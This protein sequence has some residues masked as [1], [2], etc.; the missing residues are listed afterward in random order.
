MIP[1]GDFDVI[2]VGAG[3]CGSAAAAKLCTSG[4]RVLLLERSERTARRFGEYL[5]SSACSVVDRSRL[6]DPCW[7]NEHLESNEF[8]SAW[9]G[10][11][12]ERNSILDVRGSSIVLNRARFDMSFAHAARGAGAV[13][14]DRVRLVSV[15]RPSGSWEIAFDEDGRS[16]SA[17]ASFLVLCGGRNGPRINCLPVQRRRFDKLVCLGMRLTSYTGDVRPAVETYENGWAYSVGVPGGELMINLFTE[18]ERGSSFHPSKSAEFFL[19]E[20][21]QCGIA[22]SRVL[23][24]NAEGI[25]EIFSAD[26]SSFRARPAVGP[27]W[28][29]AGDCAQSMDPLSSSGIMHA[30]EHAECLAG[31]L[32]RC[33]FLAGAVLGQY[34]Q[35]LDAKY[36]AYLSERSSVYAAER[37]R[38]G[39]FWRRRVDNSF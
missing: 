9:G 5:S 30:L 38:S 6:L 20:I 21:S 36:E 12:S 24:G 15:R 37:R 18:S 19:R 32:E 33:R 13:L 31:E 3:V 26:A 35:H 34:G 4:F 17:S 27:G 23:S 28:C 2:V 1:S 25:A 11:P 7:R 16:H 39:T 22:A 10:P 14:R 29:L 8:I